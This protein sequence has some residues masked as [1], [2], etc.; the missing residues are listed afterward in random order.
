MTGNYAMDI[1]K[2][3]PNAWQNFLGF[4]YHL[5]EEDNF[6][7]SSMDVVQKACDGD[8]WDNDWWEVSPLIKDF[9]KTT[10]R[11]HAILTAKGW[12]AAIKLD[13]GERDCMLVGNEEAT[14]ALFLENEQEALML[15]VKTAFQSLEQDLVAN[16]ESCRNC[17]FWSALKK[18]NKPVGFCQNPKFLTQVSGQ[19]TSQN[20]CCKHYKPIQK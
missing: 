2:D 4:C 12:G 3:Y 7:G 9:F 6:Y 8:W 5:D 1:K 19:Q 11:P 16:I 20:F 10:Y 13:D 15:S 14:E 18:S 17:K